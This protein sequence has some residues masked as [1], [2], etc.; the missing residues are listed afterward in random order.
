MLFLRYL[1]FS[2]A[3]LAISAIIQR[4]V[5]IL[6]MSAKPVHMSKLADL[7]QDKMFSLATISAHI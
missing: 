4:K 6:K 1:N 2:L 3:V 7:G 5:K